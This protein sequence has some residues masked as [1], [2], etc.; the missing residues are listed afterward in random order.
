[1][2]IMKRIYFLLI[3]LF[4]FQAS[5]A[6]VTLCKGYYIA[7]SGDSVAC[8]FEIP[9]DRSINIPVYLELQKHVVCI[10]LRNGKKHNFAPKHLNKFVFDFDTTCMQ[11]FSIPFGKKN[12]KLFVKKVIS[13][14]LTIYEYYTESEARPQDVGITVGYGGYNSGFGNGM[15]SVRTG[16]YQNFLLFK[17]G[18]NMTLID[19]LNFK[20]ALSNY[21]EDAPELAD[22]IRKGEYT[23]KMVNTIGEVY[24]L[25]HSK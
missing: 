21:F 11:F 14:Y 10:D 3:S 8:T 1:M 22:K 9:T 19:G 13:G 17:Q 12:A 2:N 16:V 25:N 6:K 5:F 20:A 15:Y 7:L 23:K 4:F 24:N 18:E